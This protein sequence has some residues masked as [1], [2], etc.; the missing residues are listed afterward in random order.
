[1]ITGQL[2]VFF[3][4]VLK[5][6]PLVAAAFFLAT[7]PAIAAPLTGADLLTGAGLSPT[8]TVADAVRLHGSGLPMGDTGAEFLTKGSSS[9]AWLT[10]VPGKQVYVDCDEAP[11]N[12]PNDSIGS[13]CRIATGSDWK[14]ALAGL[15]EALKQ[16]EP[17]KVGAGINTAPPPS[18]EQV[19]HTVSGADEGSSADDDDD[20]FFEVARTFHAPGYTIGVEACPRIK[21]ERNGNWHAGVVITWTRT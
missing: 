10:F 16:G 9:D 2:D 8:S 13:L 1:L 19:G 6:R 7:T 14:V 4:K 12:L 18:D 17:R 5:M 21:T 15:Q 3:I 20:A 11:A